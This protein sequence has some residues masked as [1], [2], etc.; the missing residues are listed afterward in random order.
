[1]LFFFL[2]GAKIARATQKM[3]LSIF[4]ITFINSFLAMTLGMTLILYA[5]KAGNVGMVA[6]LSSTTPI[7][8]LPLLW[9]YT[10]RRPSRFAWIGALLAVIG[11]G[12][13]VQ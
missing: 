7:M 13:L 3:N 2:S 11:T 12:V 10:G 6:L 1:M 9:I 8:L 5:L 4:K